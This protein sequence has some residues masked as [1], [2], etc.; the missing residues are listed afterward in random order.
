MKVFVRPKSSKVYLSE[1]KGPVPKDGFYV[2]KNREVIEY[3]KEGLL[4]EEVKKVKKDRK[5]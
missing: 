4:E 5:K 1:L 3:V 2:A